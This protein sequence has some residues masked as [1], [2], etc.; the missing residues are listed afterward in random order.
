MEN[1]NNDIKIK[2]IEKF[3]QEYKDDIWLKENIYENMTK[4][5]KLCVQLIKKVL[6]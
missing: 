1:I 4:L 3:Y 5:E 6:E 2:L